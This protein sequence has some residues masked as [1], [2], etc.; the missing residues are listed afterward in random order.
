[1][2]FPTTLSYLNDREA[3]EDALYRCVLGLDTADVTLFES[4]LIPDATFDLMGNVMKGLPEIQAGSFDK[5]SKLD[6][7]HHLSNIRVNLEGLANGTA[8][9]TA[10]AMAQ[11][12]RPG[13]GNKPDT[14]RLLSG[15]LYFV[16]VVKDKEVWKV[17]HFKAKMIWTEGDWGV[18]A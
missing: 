8:S 3:I 15:A 10:S 13:E 14:T 12:Y 6:T 7:T 2:S 11:H 9:V 17:K 18:F 5:V 4:A 1:M 16:D